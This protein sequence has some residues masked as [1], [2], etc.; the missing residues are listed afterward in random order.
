MCVCVSLNHFA[1]QE[2]LMQNCKSTIFQLNKKIIPQI[3]LYLCLCVFLM[4]TTILYAQFSVL[5]ILLNIYHLAFLCILIFE[6][7]KST[8]SNDRTRTLN[9]L[10][11]R[12]SEKWLIPG[13]Q[14]NEPANVLLCQKLS[15]AQRMMRYS[16]VHMSQLEGASPGQI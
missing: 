8:R 1:V 5:I 12:N 7:F 10:G 13:L 9:I 4:K 3:L 6:P 14:Q 15:S 2:K 11:T 16:K